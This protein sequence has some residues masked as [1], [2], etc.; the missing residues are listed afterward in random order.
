M[1]DMKGRVALVTA[2]SNGLGAEVVRQLARRG[3]DVAFTYRQ[4]AAAAKAVTAAVLIS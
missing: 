1:D 2:G 4:D 3:A